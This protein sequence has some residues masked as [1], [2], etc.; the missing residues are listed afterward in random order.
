MSRKKYSNTKGFFLIATE[1][2]DGDSNLS[3]PTAEMA[4]SKPLSALTYEEKI[5]TLAS[6]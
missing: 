2:S 4:A 5:Y 6:G 1:V 3:M